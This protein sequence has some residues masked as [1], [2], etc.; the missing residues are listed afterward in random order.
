MGRSGSQAFRLCCYEKSKLKIS[1]LEFEV[2][3]LQ[4]MLKKM[5]EGGG[6]MLYPQPMF[7]CPN[8]TFDASDLECSGKFIVI[9]NECPICA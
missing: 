7:H 1:R 4:E 6:F 8:Y 3:M 9:V 5:Q 2:I